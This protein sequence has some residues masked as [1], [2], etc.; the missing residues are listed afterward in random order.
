MCTPRMLCSTWLKAMLLCCAFGVSA[1][2][3]QSDGAYA[4]YAAEVLASGSPNQG[5]ANTQRKTQL[6][7]TQQAPRLVATPTGQN[8]VFAA[9]TGPPSLAPALNTKDLLLKLLA[10]V[11]LSISLCIGIMLVGSRF[12]QHQQG[13]RASTHLKVVDSLLVGQRTWLELVQVKEQLVVISRD[14]TGIQNVVAL[15][16]TFGEKLEEADQETLEFE[17]AAEAL[18]A[19]KGV[20]GWKQTKRRA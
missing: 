12:S 7:A 1:T 11:V 3:A 5:Q 18:L 9:P 14:A 15:P 10:G 6:T 17:K 16:T 8:A 19:Q 2:F 20:T 13:K 4:S